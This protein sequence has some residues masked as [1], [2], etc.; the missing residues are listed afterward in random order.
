[1][2]VGGASSGA[3]GAELHAFCC[4]FVFFFFK[5]RVFRTVVADGNTLLLT[6]SQALAPV[7]LYDTFLSLFQLRDPDYSRMG[8]GGMR[9]VNSFLIM[10]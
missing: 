9:P 3:G 7:Q 4:C 6:L 10:D 2:L 5:K 1:M 8:L